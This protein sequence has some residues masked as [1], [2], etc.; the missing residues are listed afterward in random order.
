[1]KFI[2]ILALAAAS[3]LAGCA[4]APTAYRA[5]SGYVEQGV[6]REVR[7]VMVQPNG[8]YN[9]GTV[10]GGTVGAAAGYTLTRNMRGYASGLGT[11]VGGAAGAAVG[12]SLG[13]RPHPGVLV[14]VQEGN[15]LVSIVQG[16]AQGLYPGAPVFVVRN[17]GAAEAVLQ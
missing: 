17:G 4:T 16:S 10:I 13:N 15:R 3:L 9:L 6:V 2:R 14:I 7:Q 12:Q 1:M 5:G 11:L 8:T